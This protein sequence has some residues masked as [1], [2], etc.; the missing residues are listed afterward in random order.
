M[1][2]YLEANSATPPRR[3]TAASITAMGSFFRKPSMFINRLRAPHKNGQIP[4]HF[5]RWKK[6]AQEKA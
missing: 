4:C 6:L 2:A 1:A 3:G 5:R